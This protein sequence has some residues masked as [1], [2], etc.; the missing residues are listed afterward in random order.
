[1]NSSYKLLRKYNMHNKK[2]NTILLANYLG[3]KVISGKIDKEGIRGYLAINN[4]EGIKEIIIDEFQSNEYKR[5][6]VAYCISLYMVKL[7]KEK[8]FATRIY[9]ND[10]YKE[11]NKEVIDYAINLLM[12]EK[13]IKKIVENEKIDSKLMYLLIDKFSVPEFVVREKLKK[14]RR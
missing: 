2:L 7:K 1:M 4:A 10:F 13:I 11:E 12:Q 9:D 6:V 14:Y 3:F 8:S 5:F